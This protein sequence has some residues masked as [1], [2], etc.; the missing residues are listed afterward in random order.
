[1]ANQDPNKDDATARRKLVELLE[2]D[3]WKFTRPALEQGREALKGVIR[4]P[5]GECAIIDYILGLLK[6]NFPLLR[7]LLGEPPGSC[8]VGWVMNNPDGRHT[9]IK[10]KIAE[11]GR[12]EYA[13]VMSCHASKHHT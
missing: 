3:E 13:L 12:R 8:G 9:Y 4:D 7:T 11:D 10:L 2:A 6:G 1:M 5:P